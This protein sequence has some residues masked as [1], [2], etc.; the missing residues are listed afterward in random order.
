MVRYPVTFGIFLLLLLPG[1]A[2]A[3]EPDPAVEAAAITPDG[4]RAQIHRLWDAGSCEAATLRGISSGKPGWIAFALAIRPYTDAW[5]SES[6]MISLGYAML[7]APNR[8]LPLI[9]DPRIGAS[10]CIPDDIDDSP[11]GQAA[12]RKRLK[13]MRPMYEQFLS[14]ALRK[15][16]GTCI[17]E[18]DRI[19]KSLEQRK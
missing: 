13:L 15:Q 14:T 4:V 18:V 11:E 9:D 6:L 17:E 16:A 3:C 5:P 10:I 7:A 2:S 12:F 8:I 1:G 19:E